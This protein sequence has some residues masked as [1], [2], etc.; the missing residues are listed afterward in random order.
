MQEAIFS[1]VPQG[2]LGQWQLSFW[3]VAFVYMLGT[4]IYLAFG[5]ADEQV[6]AAGKLSVNPGE[7]GF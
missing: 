7:A 4:I 1:S 3:V 5:S 2:S 6:W